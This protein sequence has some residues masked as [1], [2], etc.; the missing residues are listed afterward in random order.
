MGGAIALFKRYLQL[1][2]YTGEGTNDIRR[3][4][5]FG[6]I[7]CGAT[8]QGGINRRDRNYAWWAYRNLLAGTGTDV[9]QYYGAANL[10]RGGLESVGNNGFNHKDCVVLGAGHV[11]SQM[12]SS[13]CGQYALG[14]SSTPPPAQDPITPQ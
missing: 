7:S 13:A 8:A 11:D 2:M 6:D 10:T 1:N 4:Y 12:Y 9:S 5:N 14:M 3:L